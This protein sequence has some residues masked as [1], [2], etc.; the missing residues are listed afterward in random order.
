MREIRSLLEP[1]LEWGVRWANYWQV[2]GNE[3][4]SGDDPENGEAVSDN[5]EVRGFYLIRPDGTK[6][7]TWEY[8]KEV[9]DRDVRY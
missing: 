5:D 3:L 9:L 2:Y 1:S 6:A 7:P 4:A 8:F